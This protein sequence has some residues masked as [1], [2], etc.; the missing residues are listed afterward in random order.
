MQ[1]IVLQLES[2]QLKPSFKFGTLEM[3]LDIQE[4]V[5]LRNELTKQIDERQTPIAEQLSGAHNNVSQWNK[6][7]DTNFQEQNQRLLAALWETWVEWARVTTTNQEDLEMTKLK[8]DF[9]NMLKSRS[10]NNEA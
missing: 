3:E 2:E 8:R 7:Q 1:K 10:I 6:K 9:D 5:T 4:A